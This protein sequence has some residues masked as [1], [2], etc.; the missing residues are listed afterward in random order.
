[1]WVADITYLPTCEG[2]SCVSLITDAY[3]RKIVGYSVDDNMQISEVKL[4]FIGALK[5]RR[6][7]GSLSI[8]QIE[9]P[10]T[11]QRNTKIYMLS[12]I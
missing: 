9:V 5:K 11:A 1:M 7:K 2:N 8:I 10:N 12:T 6:S 4:A 3:S